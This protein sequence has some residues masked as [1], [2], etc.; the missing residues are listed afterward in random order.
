MPVQLVLVSLDLYVVV[1]R[2]RKIFN[3]NSS[4]TAAECIKMFGIGDIAQ[5]VVMRKDRF[6]KR[7]MSNSS[8]VC[9]ICC[10]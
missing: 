7:Y 2:A 3:I 5:T 1:S 8:T 10:E 9:E 4:E 6:V